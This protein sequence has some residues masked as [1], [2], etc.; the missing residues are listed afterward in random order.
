MK[1]KTFVK[2]LMAL[3]FSRNEANKD[4][5]EALAKRD[6]V[7]THGGKA[8]IEWEYALGRVDIMYNFGWHITGRRLTVTEWERAREWSKKRAKG[9]PMSTWLKKHPYGLRRTADGH[10]RVS[11]L[12][13]ANV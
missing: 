3:G 8:K 7:N 10:Y 13:D 6:H 12:E 5:R 11:A 4:C 1:R 9:H 2:Q